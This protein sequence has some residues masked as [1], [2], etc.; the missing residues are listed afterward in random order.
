MIRT[1]LITCAIGICSFVFLFGCALQPKKQ[2]TAEQRYLQMLEKFYADPLRHQR[3]DMLVIIQK[4]QKKESDD[5]NN[6]IKLEELKAFSGA[7]IF[8]NLSHRE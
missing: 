1:I 4:E 6:C 2:I 7:E 5:P 8:E 3:L